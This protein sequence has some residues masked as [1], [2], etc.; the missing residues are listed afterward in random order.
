DGI[1][2]VSRTEETENADGGI[3]KTQRHPLQHVASENHEQNGRNQLFMAAESQ[4]LLQNRQHLRL[5][6]FDIADGSVIVKQAVIIPVGWI[7]T[8]LHG[9][10]KIDRSNQYGKKGKQSRHV[11]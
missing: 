3:R 8:H 5:R 2:P 6:L 4:L 11:M 9:S 1:N 7:K 10:D